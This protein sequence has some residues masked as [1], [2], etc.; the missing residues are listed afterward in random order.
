M[1]MQILNLLPSEIPVNNHE[2]FAVKMNKKM[3]ISRAEKISWV[4][5]VSL[6]VWFFV[7][8]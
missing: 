4:V 2:Y 7:C 8:F 1:A 3:K 6:F 5:F